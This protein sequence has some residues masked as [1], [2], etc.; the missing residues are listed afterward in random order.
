M[1]V[2]CPELIVS[3]QMIPRLKTDEIIQSVSGRRMGLGAT[4]L[5]AITLYQNFGRSDSFKRKRVCSDMG[6]S[7]YFRFLI[8]KLAFMF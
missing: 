7:K 8:E 1:D 2:L 5:S 6:T 4:G 3:R